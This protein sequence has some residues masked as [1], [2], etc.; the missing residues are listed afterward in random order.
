VIGERRVRREDLRLLR[1]RG[2]YVDDIDLP[3]VVHMAAVRSTIP[4][5]RIL[6][7]DTTAAAAAEGV[8]GVYTA[9]DLEEINRPWPMHLAH[10]SLRAAEQRTLPIEKVR[11]VGE[12]VAVV[13]AESRYLAEDACELVEID[14]EPLPGSGHLAV[15]QQL[16]VAIHDGIDDN[17]AAHVVQST[18]D[19]DAALAKAPRVLRETYSI[20]RGG[21][22][23]M[24][25]RAVA[26]RYDRSMGEFLVWDATQTPH[27]IRAQMAYCYGLP[28]ER[29]RVIAPPDVGGGFGPKA[30]KYPEEIIVPWLAKLL[31]RPVK[32]VEDRYEHFVSCT[33]EH[34]Q[35]HHLEVA[36]DDEGILLGLRDVFLHDTGA[37]ASS[38]IVPLIAGT[39]VPG[40]Y[41]IPNLH[42]EFTS[43]F[44]NKVPSS[45][46]RG[47]GRPQG[48][49]V[50][51]RVM[52][53]IAADLGLDPADVRA[54][55]LIQEHEFPYA[56]GL[57]FRDGS[58]L[59]YDSGNYPGLLQKGLD[60]ID[61]VHQRELQ[62]K[63]RAEGALRGIGVSV[64]VEGV[65]LGP[66]EG[67]TVRMEST[68]RV[69]A[70][71]GAPPQGQGFETTYAQ[72][73]G[74]AF[75][76]DAD[77]VDVITGDTGAIAYGVGTFA[78]RVMAT[79]GPA[80]MT[81]AR[82]VKDKLFQSVAAVL[83]VSPNDL[84]IRGDEV[85][86][87]GTQAGMPLAEAAR[88]SNVGSP[89]VTMRPG[90]VPGLTATSYFNPSSAGYSSSVQVVVV[91]VD[92][93][94]GEVEILDWVVGHDCG[95]VINPLLVEGQV[96]GGVA[97][98][99]SNALY[100][101]SL[102]SDDGTPLTTSFLDYPI[103]S[104]R[105]LPMIALYDQETP[106]P[107]NPLGVKGAG[108]AG[109][110]GVPA[111]FASAVEDALAPLGVRIT[112]MPLSPGRIGD[113]IEEAR[114]GVVGAGV[115][116]EVNP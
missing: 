4:H 36:Y 20:N 53:R 38:L 74:E 81:A 5:A 73:C 50:M 14:Y 54:R 71:M 110:L 31:D 63:R 58:P 29:I 15:S 48:V 104:A 43:L 13:V 6:S 9:A 57:T 7:I 61:Y 82:E 45:A 2:E 59:T 109:T 42:I 107:L 37:Y 46:V 27:Q 25:G 96:L 39:T 22:H 111:V 79:A 52:D 108:E 88:M 100:E 72:I 90:T 28:E 69:T 101:E 3:G 77:K 21:G 76:I 64:A 102:Y 89:G 115:V 105:E 94:T 80:M 55:N 75:G 113:L 8:V 51:E 93:G 49:Y 106:S 78:S 33:Q 60:K 99:L 67:A 70:I 62:A 95:K 87:R 56:V 10:A 17:V 30:G 84:E 18:G 23:S 66:F 32:F 35:E 1:G 11:Y 47:A 41:R 85:G 116:G 97:H 86:V 68:G 83:E 92:P 26:A 19:V 12:L 114:A 16:P 34:L 65:G 44:T 40:P 112:S 91:E 24:E 98:G 103:P